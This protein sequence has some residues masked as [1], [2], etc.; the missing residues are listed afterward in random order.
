MK[1]FQLVKYYHLYVV[2]YKCFKTHMTLEDKKPICEEISEILYIMLQ[3]GIDEFI[4]Q[5]E[6]TDVWGKI[7]TLSNISV[8]STPSF[9]NKSLFKFM[10]I[11]DEMGDKVN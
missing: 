7:V 11:I 10:D 8:K 5:E 9:S 6:F 2:L 1:W 4:T 3:L